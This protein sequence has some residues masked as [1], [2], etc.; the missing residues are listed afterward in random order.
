MR[1]ELYSV[2]PVLEWP[3]TISSSRWKYRNNLFAHVVRPGSA[4]VGFESNNKYEVRNAMGQN[5][6]Y[7]VEENDC[8]SRQCC[9]PMR[10]FTIHIL[11]N[12]GQEVITITR[13]L[14]CTS[15]L[16]PC[17]LQEL[18]VQSPPGN[19]VGYVVQQW[20]PFSPK[21]LVANEHC[22]PVLKIHGPFCGW[23]CLPD[24]DFEILT[25]DEVSKIGKISKQ[26]SGLLREAFT[27]TDNFGIKFPMDLDVRMK[28]VMIAACFLII[29]IHASNVSSNEN[30]CARLHLD[31]ALLNPLS[32]QQRQKQMMACRRQEA[33]A[34]L[35]S[36]LLMRM[37]EAGGFVWH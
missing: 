6:F 23:S 7:A 10:S 31:S 16:F 15:C 3:V 14:K 34:T 35:F 11:D 19:T 9:G 32:T 2:G 17:C 4:L 20:H 21:F 1:S 27:D 33:A 8:L 25:M 29:P 18:E 22:E 36:L 12:F 24:V 37:V 30:S 13:P 28:A 26:W 5:V